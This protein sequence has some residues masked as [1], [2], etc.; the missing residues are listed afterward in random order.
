MLKFISSVLRIGVT[1]ALL[2]VGVILGF[3]L[4]RYYTQAPWTRD[5]RVRAEVVSV[6]P[7]VSGRITDVRWSTTHS[8]TSATFSR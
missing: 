3:G 5:G 4:W 6:A 2:T 1:L 8:S 7:E